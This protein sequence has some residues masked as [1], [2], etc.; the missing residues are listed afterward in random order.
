V[1]VPI[2]ASATSAHVA[3]TI[4]V[5]STAAGRESTGRKLGGR[6]AKRAREARGSEVAAVD[7]SGSHD[8]RAGACLEGASAGDA[9]T[10]SGAQRPLVSLLEVGAS[11]RASAQSTGR[12]RVVGSAGRGPAGWGEGRAAGFGDGGGAERCGDAGGGGE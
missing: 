5:P 8:C 3:A 4:A 10:G 9:V 6:S 12:Q 2:K 11:G 7:G 1:A